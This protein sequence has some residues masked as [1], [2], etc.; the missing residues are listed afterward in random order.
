[1]FIQVS[2][3]IHNE[4]KIRHLFLTHMAP[5]SQVLSNEEEGGRESWVL[6]EALRKG[7]SLRK[8][9]G[10]FRRV[11]R[12]LFTHV[13]DATKGRIPYMSVAARFNLMPDLNCFD[14]DGGVDY[15]R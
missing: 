10:L 13:L 3:S 5:M 11:I 15:R 4:D 2:E 14:E 8:N 9:P 1:L 6:L 12:H 7:V